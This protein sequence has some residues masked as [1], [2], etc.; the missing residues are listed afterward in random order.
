[1]SIKNRTKALQEKNGL[2]GKKKPAKKMTGQCSCLQ[3][4]FAGAVTEISLL[5]SSN[6]VGHQNH[7]LLDVRFVIALIAIR[8]QNGLPKMW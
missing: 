3:M 1:M 5:N 4:A 6:A 7:W 2:E 8:R